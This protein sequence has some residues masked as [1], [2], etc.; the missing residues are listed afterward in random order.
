MKVVS[1][2]QKE[3]N[4]FD[5]CNELLEWLMPPKVNGLRIFLR[6]QVRP[7]MQYYNALGKVVLRLSTC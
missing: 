5:Y 3:K 7:V 6:D 1:N 2:S 4:L